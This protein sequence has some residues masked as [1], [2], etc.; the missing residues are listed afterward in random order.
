[1]KESDKSNHMIRISKKT[2]ERLLL[3]KKYYR[4][5]YSD[6]ICRMLDKNENKI[7]ERRENGK[8]TE[9]NPY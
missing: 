1:M 3:F 6:A 4:E 5:T 9:S 8:D 7:P 2:K